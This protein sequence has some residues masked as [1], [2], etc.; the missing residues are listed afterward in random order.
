MV[1]YVKRQGVKLAPEY[2]G[3]L[4]EPQHSFINRHVFRLLNLLF[5]ADIAQGVLSYA[6]RTVLEFGA[7]YMR[8]STNPA[9]SRRGMEI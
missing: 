8:Q 2:L 4:D 9:A 3:L 1:A 5:L 6:K 7:K